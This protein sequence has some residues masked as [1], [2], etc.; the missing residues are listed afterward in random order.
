LQLPA[1]LENVPRIV[2]IL[3]FP[4]VAFVIAVAYTLGTSGDDDPPAQ[5]AQVLPTVSIAVS[6]PQP[7]VSPTAIAVPIRTDCAAIRGSDYRS[8]EER[9]WF[10]KN[11][12]NTAQAATATTTT[13]TVPAATARPAATAPTTVGAQAA[14]PPPPPPPPPP[15]GHFVGVEYP[16]GDQLVIPSIGV[17]AVVSG[18]DVASDGHMPDPAG[19]FNAVWYN[20]A[21]IPGLGGYVNGGN[22]VMAGHVDCAR[23][24]NGA[25]GAAVFYNNRGLAPGAEI[26]YYSGGQLYRYAVT[27]V[28]DYNSSADWASIVAAGSADLTMITC[29]GTFD[30]VA[31][32]YNLRNVVFAKRIPV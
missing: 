1:F 27:Q 25:S 30:P 31:R 21:S 24:H 2:L 12:L 15:S 19:Y 28:S 9:D 26:Q 5:Q 32:E 20:F 22:L 14:A 3:V 7:Q 11:C 29:G 8:A 23:C 4:L 17:N 10:Q 13:N 18:M 16:L 6:T